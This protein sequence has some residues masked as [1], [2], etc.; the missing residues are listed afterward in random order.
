MKSRKV[1]LLIGALLSISGLSAAPFGF[2]YPIP[3][4]F[5]TASIWAPALQLL[6][7][8]STTL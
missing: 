5:C 8:R 4:E 2:S 6:S 7:G 3:I 1:L